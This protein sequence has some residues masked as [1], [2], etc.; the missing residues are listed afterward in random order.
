MA[1]DAI[2][3]ELWAVDGNQ[4][5]LLSV[6]YTTGTFTAIGAVLTAD[7]LYWFIKGLAYDETTDLLFAI[8]DNTET[9]FT[10]DPNNNAETAWVM[11]VPSGPDLYDELQFFD[12]RLFASFKT[13]DVQNGWWVATTREIDYAAGTI[14]DVGP[15]F[16]KMSPH[17]LRITSMPE[18]TRWTQISGIGTAVF[19]DPTDPNTTV[20]FSLP[21]TYVL[22]LEVDDDTPVADAV[23]IDVYQL[24]CNANAVPDLTDIAQGTSLDGNANGIPDE[25]ECWPPASNYCTAKISTGGHSATILP[26]GLPSLAAGSVDLV[27]SGAMPSKPALMFWGYLPAAVPFQGG[28]LCVQPPLARL[29]AQ[30][31][32]PTGSTVYSI[33]IDP[34]MVT[35]LRHYQLWY[36]DPGD[37]VFGVALSDGVAV[38]YCQ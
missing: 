30:P 3:D 36:R 29:G 1:Y 34:T 17:S 12:G 15:D 18:K 20:T 9:L 27:A 31:L 19:A 21:G 24:D 35:E 28:T 10:I 7:E 38:T 14:Y 32:D 16:V 11:D 2:H 23:Q 13:W 5:R 4:K 26:A 25:C 8:D 37:P 6:D 22:E 33:P